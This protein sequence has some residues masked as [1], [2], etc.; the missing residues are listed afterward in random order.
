MLFEFVLWLEYGSLFDNDEGIELIKEYSQ[1]V[2][3]KYYLVNLE[4]MHRRFDGK[5]SSR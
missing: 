2:E 1:L 3:Q 4:Y 5:S